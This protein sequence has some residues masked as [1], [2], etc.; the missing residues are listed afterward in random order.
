MPLYEIDMKIKILVKALESNPHQE[1][2]L[3]ANKAVNCM[4]HAGVKVLDTQ[5]TRIMEGGTKCILAND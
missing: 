1:P 5:I 2:Q 3:I 4:A